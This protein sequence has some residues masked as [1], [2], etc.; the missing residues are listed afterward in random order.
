MQNDEVVRKLEGYYDRQEINP[1]HFRC[2]YA[3]GRMV[4]GPQL[5][6]ETE[7]LWF[8]VPYPGGYGLNKYREHLAN[9]R[10]EFLAALP[11]SSKYRRLTLQILRTGMFTISLIAIASFA[12]NG[13]PYLTP[14]RLP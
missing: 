2:R 7:F 11:R 1:K 13:S 12:T 10:D 4:A 3:N 14:I 8:P 6:A 5:R 9:Y